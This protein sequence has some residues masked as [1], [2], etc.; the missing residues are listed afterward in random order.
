M[1]ALAASP[2]PNPRTPAP[3]PAGRQ[4]RAWQSAAL[5]QVM[6][7][8][9]GDF[10]AAATPAAGKTTFGLRVA[11][12]LLSCGAVSRVAVV[13]P[14]AHI[15]RQW[16][17]AAAGL[18]IDLDPNRA[19][20]EGHEPSDRH[21]T[22]VTYQAI[23]A[24]P[25]VHRRAT[26]SRPT[27][28]IA[29][30]PHHMGED[31]AWGRGAELAF[32]GARLRL[33]LSG[34]P[35]RSDDAAIPFVG[36]DDTGLS[37]A[38]HTY[39][40]T[41]ALVDGVCRPITFLAY[42]GEM[43]WESGGRRR[44][45][46]FD[47]VLPKAESARR[48]RTALDAE[49]D[50]IAQV[51]RDGDARLTR[52]RAAG[53]P[54][55]GGLVIAADKAHARRLAERLAQIAGER[56][57]VVT[58]DDPDA[59]AR[60]EAFAAGRARWLVAVLMVSEGVD[61]PRLRVGVYATAART[62][63]FFRQVVGRFV[64]RTARPSRQMSYLLLPAD[65]QLKALAA[66]V[67]EERRHALDLRPGLD[68]MLG[69]PPAERLESGDGFLA[70][71]SSAHLEDVIRS[72]TQPGDALALFA[73]ADQPEFA[74]RAAGAGPGP[75][76]IVAQRVAPPP[77][78]VLRERAR[79]TRNRLVGDLARLTGESHATIHAEVNRATGARTVADATHEQLDDGNARLERELARVSRSRGRRRA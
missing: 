56:V 10:L 63:L 12:A 70:L 5:E 43:E 25:V 51:L 1:E 39:G 26:A 64:R 46:G 58:S 40:Y 62:E 35:F 13:G 11:H 66:T 52:V 8:P 69:E 44:R 61:I 45:A 41:K 34:T 3:W 21:G 36:Y 22:A 31:A 59:S 23:A 16:A 79:E 77:A 2:R 30:E 50:W 9:S 4:L 47:L 19:N 76:E 49:G 57:E 71:S 74:T 60:I 48:L 24:G 33:L 28:L 37:R 75:P 14:T 67:E 73:D 29:D 53:H 20:A 6:A 15:C 32:G 78:Y 7:R 17:A 38:D 68:E 55:A 18:G 27:L 42:D 72:T 54:D 65:P